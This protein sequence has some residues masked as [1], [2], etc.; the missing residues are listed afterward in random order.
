MNLIQ[1]N[2]YKEESIDVIKA[3]LL[4]LQSSINKK[5][6]DVY[7]FVE[8]I[9]S[10]YDF[11]LN[12]HKEISIKMKNELLSIINTSILPKLIEQYN[13][14]V[15]IE[16]STENDLYPLF[17]ILNDIIII[18]SFSKVLSLNELI[19][20][21]EFYKKLMNVLDLPATKNIF[22]FTNANLNKMI[23]IYN[24]E[25]NENEK[26][27]IEGMFLYISFN[28]IESFNR[29]ISDI[30]ALFNSEDKRMFMNNAVFMVYIKRKNEKIMKIT[31]D[32]FSIGYRIGETMLKEGKTLIEKNK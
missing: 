18:T 21:N 25:E 31:K 13:D 17:E 26:L 19:K 28:H 29:Y 14:I 24:K 32:T 15:N 30:I 2:S 23:E 5:M 16:L 12:K 3:I 10:I 9:K 8:M 6:N 22:A 1:Y 4:N 7:N 20:E 27:F 11:A